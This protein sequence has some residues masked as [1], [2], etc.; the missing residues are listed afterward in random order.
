M[1]EYG[2]RFF[3]GQPVVLGED[4]ASS[5][6]SVLVVP[7]ADRKTRSSS[8]TARIAVYDSPAA[9]PR[10]EEVAASAQDLQQAAESLDRLVS[11]SR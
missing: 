3:G 9:A 10:T 4:G 8:W 7:G 5:H 1:G 6:P 11:L 2:K